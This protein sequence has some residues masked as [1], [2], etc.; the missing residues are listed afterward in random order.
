MPSA[1][2][3]A[4]RSTVSGD[5]PPSARHAGAGGLLAGAS[6]LLGSAGLLVALAADAIAV[7]GRHL[8]VPF[9]GSIETVQAAV[10]VAASSAMVAATLGRAHAT[11]RILTGRLSAAGRRRVQVFTDAVSALFFAA[12]AAG[13]IWI[14]SDLWDG[15][16][17][18]ELLGLPIKPLRLFWCASAVLMAGLFVVFAFRRQGPVRRS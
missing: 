5:A 4:R 3:A 8:G 6:F 1:G 10:I 17:T 7:A 11:V 2:E 13:S 12:V 16:E 18:T 15:A 9:L 14:V